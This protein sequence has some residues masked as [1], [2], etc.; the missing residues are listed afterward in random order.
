DN[1]DVLGLVEFILQNAGYTVHACPTPALA[2]EKALPAPVDLVITDVQMPGMS[3]PEFVK[4][5]LERYPE[6]AYLFISGYAEDAN[7]RLRPPQGSV[8]QKPFRPQQLLER[9]RKAL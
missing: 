6:T 9:V 5:W 7:L 4:C 2:L 3:G 8:L 1:A